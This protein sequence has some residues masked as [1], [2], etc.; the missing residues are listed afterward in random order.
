ML[1]AD[2]IRIEPSHCRNQRIRGANCAEC[3]SVCPQSAIRLDGGGRPAL[4]GTC[5][6]C[7]LC[8]AVCPA[9]AIGWTQAPRFPL[10][11]A[12][13]EAAV[14]CTKVKCD[15]YADC[16][17]GLSAWELAYLALH[18]R[19]KLVMDAKR[20]A[21]CNVGVS[22][23]VERQTANANQFLSRLKAPPIQIT[24]QSTVDAEKMNRRDLFGFFLT[25]MKQTIAVALPMSDGDA[26]YRALLVG[27]LRQRIRDCSGSAAPLF[28][29]IDVSRSCK[30]CGACV[31]A[32]KHEALKIAPAE[33]SAALTL[34]H[35]QRRCVGCGVCEEI[36]RAKAIAIN[37]ARSRLRALCDGPVQAL[38]KPSVPCATC[39]AQIIADAAQVC[40]A[41]ARKR[42]KKI[43]SI[44]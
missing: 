10:T 11:I 22:R 16:L 21:A 12:D 43:Q 29:G 3:E 27:A 23:Q 38:S 17:G 7:G 31:K 28:Y 44:Y 37:P 5:V 32:C 30:L 34:Y 19:V 35:D 14:Y 42:A 8:A 41:C 39:G 2:K 1:G 20:C 26:D 36:C 9:R 15:G 6:N 18:A 25:K 24:A 40:A 13:G 33:E 4:T